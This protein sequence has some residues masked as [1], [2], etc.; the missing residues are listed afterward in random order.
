M[1]KRTLLLTLGLLFQIIQ[2]YKNRVRALKKSRLLNIL[3][4][5]TPLNPS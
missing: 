2:I 4:N 1:K 3:T 5:L